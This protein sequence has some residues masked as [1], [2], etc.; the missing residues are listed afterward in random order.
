SPTSKKKKKSLLSRFQRFRSFERIIDNRSS[1]EATL[2][3]R[4]KLAEPSPPLGIW[5]NDFLLLWFCFVQR[6]EQSIMA[7]SDSFTYQKAVFEKL[8]SKSENN[9]CFDCNA[10]NTTWASATYGVFICDH[11]SIVHRLLGA[12]VSF[13]RSTTLDSWSPEHLRIM[14]LGGNNRAQ[15]FFKQH[16]WNDG[17]KTEAKYA[18]RAAGLYREILSKEV[19]KSSAED[20]ELYRQIL[21]KEVAK[22]SADDAELYRQIL[23]EVAKANALSE[24]APVVTSCTV[25]KPF[26]TKRTGKSGGL[27]ARKF[28][29]KLHE[30]LYDQKPEEAPLPAP[31]VKNRGEQLVANLKEAIE[32]AYKRMAEMDEILLRIRLQ[33]HNIDS[34]DIGTTIRSA[35]RR[36][37]DTSR[38]NLVGEIINMLARFTNSRDSVRKIARSNLFICTAKQIALLML[39][40]RLRMA[41]RLAAVLKGMTG[42]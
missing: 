3:D 16:G 18:S 14:E 31:V 8:K 4:S 37:I 42:S 1:E 13:V 30:N 38:T 17:G 27:S 9:I 11:C 28:T 2:G 40:L 26:G 36:N 33:E 34:K 29:T 10:K 32:A 7:A 35:Q 6:N 15:V 20:A 12:D 22:S 21:S 5:T 24:V 23:S 39:W 41:S 25:E 19:A